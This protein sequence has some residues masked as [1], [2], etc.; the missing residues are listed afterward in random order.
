MRSKIYLSFIALFLSM[1]FSSFSQEK[2]ESTTVK[3]DI[4]KDSVIN[5]KKPLKSVTE[6]S[7]TVEGKKINYEAVAGT[8]VL[9][10]ETDTPTI[11]MSYVAYFKNDEKDPS[12]RPITFIY[13]GGPEVLRCGSTWA[14]GAHKEFF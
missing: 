9:N 1:S 6:G 10:N 12:L 4:K 14:L 11:S 5:Y 2:K 13:N 7:V 8:L 3:V